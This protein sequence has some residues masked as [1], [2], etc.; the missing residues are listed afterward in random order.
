MGPIPILKASQ[1]RYFQTFI[2]HLWERG[3]MCTFVDG[4]GSPMFLEESL[5][6]CIPSELQVFILVLGMLMKDDTHEIAMYIRTHIHL[7]M[8]C[9]LRMARRIKYVV[10]GRVHCVMIM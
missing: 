3:G 5:H 2:P 7:I 6:V 1:Y 4:Y 10:W 9:Q 8:H